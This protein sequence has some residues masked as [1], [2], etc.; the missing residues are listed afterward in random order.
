MII[1]EGPDGAGKSTLVR[2]LI[3]NL[4]LEEGHRATSDRDKL[5]EVTRQDTYTALATEVIGN[6]QLGPAKIWDRLFFSEMVYAPVVGRDCEFSSDEQVF[7]RRIM[8]ALAC[9]II[10][11]LPPW[12]VVKENVEASKQMDGVEENLTH[13]YG[14]YRTIASGMPWVMFYDYTG[15]AND[16]AFKTL[17]GIIEGCSSY[18]TIRQRRMW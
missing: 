1:V 7:V 10:I 3:E 18:L 9:P 17:T 12:D 11:C 2:E 8:S 5:Y 4:Q 6:C 14:T 13:I 16:P 15:E